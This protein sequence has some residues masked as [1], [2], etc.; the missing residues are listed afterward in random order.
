MKKTFK[1]I[2]KFVKDKQLCLVG[3]GE[4]KCD[5]SNFDSRIFV[6]H[7]HHELWQPNDIL[8]LNGASDV[9]PE[10]IS[11]KPKVRYMICQ[12]SPLAP[13]L[14]R[15]FPYISM[16]FFQ[17]GANYSPKPLFLKILWNEQL[18]HGK[19]TCLIG[20]MAVYF[21]AQ[22]QAK[23]I[24]LTGFDFYLN[25]PTKFLTPDN[26]SN[27]KTLEKILKSDSRFSIESELD[28]ALNKLKGNNG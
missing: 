21:L 2:F 14:S 26:K 12:I 17:G 4:P 22:T 24:H 25:H 8:F 28:I 13:E 15:T 3:G 23:S 10:I 16:Y 9:I 6:N 1:D 19:P 7:Y 27:A 5:L 11:L 18:K 20:I